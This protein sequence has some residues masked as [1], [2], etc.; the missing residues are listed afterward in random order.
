MNSDD[1]QSDQDYQLLATK[2]DAFMSDGAGTKEEKKTI[3]E[4]KIVNLLNRFG[5]QH[6]CDELA[7]MIEYY[8]NCEA[9]VMQETYPSRRH[10]PYTS[11]ALSIF[12]ILF[13]LFRYYF[14][15]NLRF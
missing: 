4:K 8:E 9:L 14:E 7:A 1:M 13:V 10:I 5:G 12:V 3:L 15:E 6:W 11:Y 2:F